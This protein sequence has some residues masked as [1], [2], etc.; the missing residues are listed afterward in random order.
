MRL[1]WRNGQ[2]Y[3]VMSDYLTDEPKRI[4]NGWRV[5][6]AEGMLPE[7]NCDVFKTSMAGVYQVRNVRFNVED[8]CAFV[9]FTDIP[10]PKRVKSEMRWHYGWEKMTSRGWQPA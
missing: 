6:W 1:E 3:L 2:A 8:K 9:E 5:T 10:K 4:T 7:D